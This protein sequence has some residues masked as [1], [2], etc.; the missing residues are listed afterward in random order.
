MKNCKTVAKT[1]NLVAPGTWVCPE[2]K[3]KVVTHVA[4]YP[5]ECRGPKHSRRSVT[6]KVE[7]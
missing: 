6:M 1:S 7:E 5:V 4:T 3:S 2:C